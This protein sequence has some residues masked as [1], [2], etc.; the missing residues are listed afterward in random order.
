MS[1]FILN[2]EDHDEFIFRGEREL[3]NE[4]RAIE[5]ISEKADILNPQ[6]IQLSGKSYSEEAAKVLG[7]HFIK[8]SAVSC[9]NLSNIWKPI[10]F[11]L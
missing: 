6:K 2:Y 1:S 4:A 5:L 10:F 7:D 11:L 3:V 9:M 8:F